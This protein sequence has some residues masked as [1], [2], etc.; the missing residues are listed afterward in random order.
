MAIGVVSVH[1]CIGQVLSEVDEVMLLD[2]N[3]PKILSFY[4]DPIHFVF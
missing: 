3:I 4:S 1:N 2:L